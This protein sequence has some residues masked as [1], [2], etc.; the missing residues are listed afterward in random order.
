MI[1]FFNSAITSVIS[2][3]LFPT[4]L[5]DGSLLKSLRV[6]NLLSFFYVFFF[7]FLNIFFLEKRYNEVLKAGHISIL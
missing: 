5:A 4:T 3:V 1:E 2:Q 6:N 7:S